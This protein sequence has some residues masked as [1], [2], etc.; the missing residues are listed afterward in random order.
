MFALLNRFALFISIAIASIPLIIDWDLFIFSLIIFFVM[1]L[2]I[3]S[4]ERIQRAVDEGNM[5]MKN[6]T[7][8]I[9]TQTL[10]LG[11]KKTI[12]N[13]DEE[14]L[15]SRVV[16]PSIDSHGKFTSQSLNEDTPIV[17]TEKESEVIIPLDEPS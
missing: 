1:R 5:A 16:E 3:F 7:P 17:M 13:I 4:S 15:S 10:S 6:I 11:E 8:E 14:R 12:Y 9:D 2:G